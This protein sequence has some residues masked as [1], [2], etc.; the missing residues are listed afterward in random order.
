VLGIGDL[1]LPPLVH[2]AEG[3]SDGFCL[4]DRGQGLHHRSRE[5]RAQQRLDP[6]EREGSRGAELPPQALDVEGLQVIF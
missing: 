5:S 2:G 6:N 1:G 4:R 3:I